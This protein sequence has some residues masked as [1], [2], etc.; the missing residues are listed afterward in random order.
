[1]PHSADKSIHLFDIYKTGLNQGV[2]PKIIDSF[3]K[4]PL[5]IG[6]V[7]KNFSIFF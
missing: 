7:R 6:G 4:Y 2:S 3:G 5:K 1:M